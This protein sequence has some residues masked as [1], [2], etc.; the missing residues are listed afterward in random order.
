[1]TL[2]ATSPAKVLRTQ[3]PAGLLLVLSL[4][5]GCGRADPPA[6]TSS[7]PR[8][9]AAE[10]AKPRS[11]P[12]PHDPAK[13]K[14]HAL[15]SDAFFAGPIPAFEIQLSRAS[16]QSLEREPRLAVPGT[17][18]VGTNRYERVAIHVKGAAG[19]SRSVDDNPALTLNFDKLN[20]GQR[21]HGLDKIHLNN[22]VQDPSRM[23][24]IVCSDQYLSVGIPTAR[25]T[26]ALLKLNGRDLGLYV[27]KEGYN[28]TFLDRFFTNR[29]G[30]LYDGGF[31]RDID[32]DLE[33]DSGEGPDTHAD[34][35]QLY[36]ACSQSD[37]TRRRDALRK[38]LDV[39]RFVTYTALQVLT[40]DWDGYPKNRNNYRL[41][42]DAD[43]GR[44]IFIPHGMDQMFS[45]GYS[46]AEGFEGI[47][48]RSTFQ[49]PEFREMYWQQLSALLNNPFTTEH[50]LATFDAAVERRKP[51]LAL[52]PRDEQR[53]INGATADI[54]RRIIAR[55]ENARAQLA[56]RPKPIAFN[57]KGEAALDN[58][59]PHNTEA[60]AVRSTL[61]TEKD[62]R[63]L[64]QLAAGQPGAG[65]WRTRVRLPPGR[66]RI[67]GSG[68]TDKV[69]L[70]SD[71]R[72]KGLGIRVSGVARQNQLFGTQDWQTLVF[73]FAMPGDGEIEVVA[74]LR[75]ASGTGWF[76]PATML[77][78]R[79]PPP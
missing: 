15:E 14:R 17:V 68:K 20:P 65:S 5:G 9:A 38:I 48:A 35:K 3:F 11:E 72:G 75:A 21:F 66:Y 12:A 33:R 49:I 37:L 71:E 50:L 41:Y 4:F 54:R 29:T 19:S 44:F 79:L 55:V 24:E 8:P 63:K 28:K 26:H 43:T 74:E 52:L 53:G 58:W 69:A 76:D 22:S 18:L 36:A 23:S 67:Q 16:F 59:R 78:R 2:F 77:I 25:A 6:Q 42:H 60:D 13:A 39:D 62:G 73:D 27:L 32:Q 40:D 7:K 51:A 64:Y 47:V 46:L 34:L 30:N 70:L 1:M 31:L 61:L 56:G 45:R 10:V 57:A